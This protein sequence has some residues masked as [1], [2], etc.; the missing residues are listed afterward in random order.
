MV[1]R[2]TKA[3]YTCLLAFMHCIWRSKSLEFLDSPNTIIADFRAFNSDLHSAAYRVTISSMY[4]RPASES[5]TR[6]KSS[7]YM[8]A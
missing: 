3:V 5:L 1:G 8:G 2:R 4:W 6:A 7:A